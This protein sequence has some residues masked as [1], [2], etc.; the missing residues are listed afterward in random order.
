MNLEKQLK[1]VK[2]HV[3]SSF[4]HYNILK[5]LHSWTVPR[6]ITNRGRKTMCIL[7]STFIRPSMS[8]PCLIF[9]WCRHCFG[10][11]INGYWVWSF[12]RLWCR[13]NGND[14]HFRLGIVVWYVF[15]AHVQGHVTYWEWN[16]WRETPSGRSSQRPSDRPCDRAIGRATD[17]TIERSTEQRAIEQS[18][19]RTIERSRDAA[20]ERANNRRAINS[21][22]P[23]FKTM[24][25]TTTHYFY[26]RKQ[27]NLM[28]SITWRNDSPHISKQHSK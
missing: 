6:L 20:I 8:S 4:R 21:T 3:S 23:L 26:T 17:R 9:F 24:L 13:L 27:Q 25:N 12:M 18:S 11:R 14:C 15:V 16:S 5:H 22:K 28:G 1:F 7:L 10:L 2:K 19:D